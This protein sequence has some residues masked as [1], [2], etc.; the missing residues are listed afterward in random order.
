MHVMLER[1]GNWVALT[2]RP[3]TIPE[4]QPDIIAYRDTVAALAAHA[5]RTDLEKACVALAPLPRQSLALTCQGTAPP[6]F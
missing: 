1:E 3:E 2:L 4:L 6:P 5:D